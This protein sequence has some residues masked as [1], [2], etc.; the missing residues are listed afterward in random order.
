MARRAAQQAAWHTGTG[1]FPIN[2][3]ALDDPTDKAWV[4]KHP[5]F[6]TAIDELNATKPSAANAGCLL[7]VMPQARQGVED[8]IEQTISGSKTARQAL[9]DAA[10]AIQPAIDNYNNSVG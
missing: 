3:K 2:G 1:Y 5:Q 10:K 8:A 4:A 9:A 7:G 6:Q